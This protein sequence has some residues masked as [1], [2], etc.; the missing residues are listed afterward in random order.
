MYRQRNLPIK[1]GVLM[2]YVYQCKKCEKETTIERAMDNRDDKAICVFC[3]EE[4]KRII[5]P[6]SVMTSDGYKQ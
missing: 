2:Y 6:P 5:T 1:R 4:M 3:G